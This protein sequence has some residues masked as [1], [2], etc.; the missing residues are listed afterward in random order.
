MTPE[1]ICLEYV[2]TDFEL[3]SMPSPMYAAEYKGFLKTAQ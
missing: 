2:D 1:L 3:I